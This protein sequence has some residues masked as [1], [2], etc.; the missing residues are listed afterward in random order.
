MDG[1]TAEEELNIGLLL[2]IPYRWLE[3]R[4]FAAV[5]DAGHSDLTTAQMKLMQRIGTSGTR[6]T[7]LAEQAQVTKPTASYL[8]DQ[9][10]ARGWVQRVPDPT[11]GRARLVRLTARAEQVI[12]IAN[13]AIAEVTAEWETHLGSRQ[14]S[15]L[16]RALTA[17][18]QISD[19][20]QDR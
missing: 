5:A 12:P 6:L 7:D 16:R 10:E 3:N 13:A 1:D 14:M 8:V 17:L 18:R 2:Y 20:Y 19:P 11:D 15:Q 9:L 4:V